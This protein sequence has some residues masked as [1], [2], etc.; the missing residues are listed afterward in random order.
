MR[1]KKSKLNLP[2]GTVRCTANRQDGTGVYLPLK[3]E[4]RSFYYLVSRS[5]TFVNSELFDYTLR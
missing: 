2:V 5:G 1:K 4:N 3:I